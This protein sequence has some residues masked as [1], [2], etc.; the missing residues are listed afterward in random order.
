MLRIWQD[1]LDMHL[2]LSSIHYLRRSWKKPPCVPLIGL[3]WMKCL[4]R[5]TLCLQVSTPSPSPFLSLIYRYHRPL[6]N[7]DAFGT[8][9]SA[10]HLSFYSYTPHLPSSISP[11]SSLFLL[12]SLSHYTLIIIQMV[13]VM[14]IYW[15]LQCYKEE[16]KS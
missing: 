2:V 9:Q 5:V 4:L 13:V 8:N 7:I 10:C 12:S 15:S 11:L 14:K 16:W 6:Y 3:L 1:P